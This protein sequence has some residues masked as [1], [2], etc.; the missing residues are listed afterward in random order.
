MKKEIAIGIVKRRIV[1]L[2]KRIQKAP[3]DKCFKMDQNE[4]EA[5]KIAVQSLESN[6]N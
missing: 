6:I 5:L 2:E 1:F 3:T 4:V